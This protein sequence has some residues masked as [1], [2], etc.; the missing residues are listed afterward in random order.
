MEQLTN[1]IVEMVHRFFSPTPKFFKTLRT[2]SLIL[3]TI[4]SIPSL[5]SVFNI[6]LDLGVSTIVEKIVAIAA[7]VAAIV[8][9]LAKE[10][11]N[12]TAANTTA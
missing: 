5:L 3:A 7:F 10:D 12:T 1:F 4:A 11:P 6:T 9:Q 2:I 8:S